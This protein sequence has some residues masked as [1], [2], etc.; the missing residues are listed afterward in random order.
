M[1][2]KKIIIT[3]SSDLATDQRVLKE[4]SSLHR[5]GY[6]IE[7]FCRQ[8]D[9]SLPLPELPYKIHRLKLYR[10]SGMGLF[11]HLNW[12][13][14]FRLLRSN[15]SLFWANDLDTLLPVYL[16]SRLKRKPLVYDSHEYYT[17]MPSLVNRPLK[18]KIWETLERL[19]FPSL[20][21][22]FTVNQ[23]IAGIY[24]KKYQVPVKVLR[25]VPY[26]M[27]TDKYIPA[28]IDTGNRKLLLIQGAGIHKDRGNEEA[29]QAMKYLDDGYLLLII[30]DGDALPDLKKYVE[31]EQLENRV[32]FIPKMPYQKLVTYTMRA[33]LGL[34]VEHIHKS[35]SSS[36]TLPNKIF[37]YIQA[38]LPVLAARGLE[39]ERIVKE[40]QIGALIPSHVPEEMAA[41]IRNF[42]ADENRI[43]EYRR[44]AI[45]AARILCWEK[46]ETVLIDMIR[47]IE[48]EHSIR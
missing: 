5:L 21:Y 28:L 43:S 45:R 16:V 47:K 46:E 34:A 22:V 37:D 23:T 31:A 33:D 4:C 8:L 29:V 38:G 42:F 14:F 27:Q 25:N 12:K 6:T 39:L 44:N 2:L 41:A 7:I 48:R 1:N 36:V 9:D 18:K 20:K 40:Y 11:L 26:S 17:E 35:P 15:T 19:I 32:W 24:E 13:L 10:E 30:G 3:V